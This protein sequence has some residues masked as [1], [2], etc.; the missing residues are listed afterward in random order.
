MAKS[1]WSDTGRGKS[2]GGNK[3]KSLKEFADDLPF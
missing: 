2:S 3:P 1:G